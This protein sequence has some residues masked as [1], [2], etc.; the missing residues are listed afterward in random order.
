MILLNESDNSNNQAYK[1]II[2]E[3]MLVKMTEYQEEIKKI[4]NN[5][6]YTHFDTED[7]YKMLVS[8]VRLETCTE[9]FAVIRNFL[10]LIK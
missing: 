6:F 1:N 7:Y 2:L 9:T 10:H 3:Y 4:K 5:K 8:Q